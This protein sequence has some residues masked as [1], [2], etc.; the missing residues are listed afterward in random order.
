MSKPTESRKPLVTIALISGLGYMSKGYRS[1]LWRLMA[2]DLKKERANF[3]IVAGEVVDARSIKRFLKDWLMGVRVHFRADK[4]REFVKHHAEYLAEHFPRIR[5]LKFHFITSPAYDGELG[6]EIV[7]AMNEIRSDMRLHPN[8]AHKIFPIDQLVVNKVKLN[9]GVYVPQAGS[10]FYSKTFDTHNRRVLTEVMDAIGLE[11][12]NVVGCAASAVLNP[13]DSTEFKKPYLSTP[14]LS[15]IGKSK[16]A[17]NQVGIVF[18]KFYSTNM[19]EVTAVV[20]SY[21][22]LVNREWALVEPPSGATSA[23]IALLE[24]MKSGAKTAGQLADDTGQGRTAVA[25]SMKAL[26]KKSKST[27]SWPGVALNK[28]SKEYYYDLKW[29]QEELDYPPLRWDKEESVL[30][31]GCLH[32]GSV[33]TDMKYFVEEV[34]KI[35]LRNNV[36]Y[37]CGIGDLIQGLK[38]ELMMLGEVVTDRNLLFNYTNQ[39]KLAAYLVCRVLMSDFEERIRPFLRRA[40]KKAMKVSRV[41]G[42]V[43][44]ALA[45]FPFIYGNHCEWVAPMGYNPLDTFHMKLK[46][47]LGE[48]IQRTLA[49]GKLH[50]PDMAKVLKARVIFLGD[51]ENRPFMMPSGLKMTMVHPRLSR[52]LVTSARPQQILQKKNAGELV[53]AA[54]FHE[55]EGVPVHEPKRGQRFCLM[56]GT[57]MHETH[58]ENGKL[59]DVTFGVGHVKVCSYRGR[60]QRTENAFYGEP[61]KNLQEANGEVLDAFRKRLEL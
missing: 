26:E 42:E 38:H 44:E 11:E 48:E 53:L 57:L 24:H 52:T 22:D 51:G 27:K 7:S 46:E 10:V 47:L 21:K 29:F 19:K 9:L 33:H 28:K 31:F 13:G 6:R 55:G 14:K 40:G 16:T 20:N 25:D 54:N 1:G 30:G 60:I 45:T 41:E 18:L 49:Q 8:D 15:K 43:L 4:T 56:A 61:T 32:A 59:K 50:L 35:M 34:P 36:R 5:G 2:N 58:F 23:Q 37:L 39:E 3:A 17:G 12:L